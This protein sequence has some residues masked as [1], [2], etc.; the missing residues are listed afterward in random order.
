[1]YGKNA[2]SKY[3]SDTKAIMNFAEGYKDFITTAKTERLAVKEAV[4]ILDAKGFKN[5]DSV[6]SVKEGDKVYFINKS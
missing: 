5:A 6:K 2:W 4:K 3:G 1:M